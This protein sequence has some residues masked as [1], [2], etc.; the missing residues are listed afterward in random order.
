MIWLGLVVLACWHPTIGIPILIIAI[1]VA[2][3]AASD[4]R[5][6]AALERKI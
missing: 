3:K 2:N 5:Y 1:G 4:A 6:Q